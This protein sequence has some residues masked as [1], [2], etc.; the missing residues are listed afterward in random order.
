M[1]G[2]TFYAISAEMLSQCSY[3]DI[4][5]PPISVSTEALK[6]L[7]TLDS[8]ARSNTGCMQWAARAVGKA[9]LT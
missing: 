1:W 5:S 3:L 9:E 2:G 6:A 4:S 8:L 7:K